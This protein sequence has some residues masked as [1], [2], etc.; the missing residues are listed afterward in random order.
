MA[1]L[2]NPWNHT[3]HARCTKCGMRINVDYVKGN[4]RPM[5]VF[6]YCCVECG[7]VKFRVIKYLEEPR[8]LLNDSTVSSST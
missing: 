8:S 4:K 7:T 3:V 6:K 5:T 2:A 1:A